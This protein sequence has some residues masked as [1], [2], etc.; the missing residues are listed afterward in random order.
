[1]LGL[2]KMFPDMFIEQVRQLSYYSNL[3]LFWEVMAPVFFEMSDLYD[4][5]KIT[6]VPEAM[7]FLVNGF[8]RSPD[9]RFIIMYILTVNATK[10]FLNP[11]ALP[12]CMKPLSLT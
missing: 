2:Y 10:L 3:G 9:A 12:G 7:N 5:G 6:S 8:L 4:E 11:K 1:M